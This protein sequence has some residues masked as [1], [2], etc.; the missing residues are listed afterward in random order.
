MFSNFFHSDHGPFSFNIVGGT[1][2][3]NRY[4]EMKHGQKYSVNITNNSLKKC[5]A[6]LTIDGS[7]M[8]DFIIGAHSNVD[9]DRPV[10]SHKRFTFYRTDMSS[11]LTTG[12]IPACFNNGL[13]EVTFIPEKA[14][15]YT[16][17]S[18]IFDTDSCDLESAS[19]ST[20]DIKQMS[21]R[22]CSYAEGGTALSGHSHQHFRTVSSLKLDYSKQVTLSY[23]LVGV[24]GPLYDDYIEPIYFKQIPPPPV[25]K[26]WNPIYDFGGIEPFGPTI[27][28]DR[29]C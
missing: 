17:T 22:N 1:H 9:I 5:Q 28:R 25:V 21:F 27:N 8:G 3:H 26:E 2:T 18:S 11:S 12:I 10:H 16:Y 13:V 23:R 14:H 4:V 6:S 15:T 19:F 20:N 7:H 29:Y 24:D